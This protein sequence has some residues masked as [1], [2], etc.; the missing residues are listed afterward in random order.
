MGVHSP[1][2]LY[3]LLFFPLLPPSWP[4]SSSSYALFCLPLFGT[5]SGSS[6]DDSCFS[7][8]SPLETREPDLAALTH[9]AFPDLVVLR[10]LLA[11]LHPPGDWRL[12]ADMKPCLAF[13]YI[14][15][16]L[17]HSRCPVNICWM[18]RGT[19]KK[20]M[21]SHLTNFLPVLCSLAPSFP[22]VFLILWDSH[23]LSYLALPILNLFLK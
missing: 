20:S 16:C 19:S 2:W 4:F 14:S 12:R 10:H 21:L 9:C 7:V 3:L 17:A 13:C 22:F 23:L 1:Y 11:C 5:L 15:W 18:D 6:P 8:R